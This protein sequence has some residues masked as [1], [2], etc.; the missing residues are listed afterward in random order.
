MSFVKVNVLLSST[1][2]SHRIWHRLTPEQLE[3][4]CPYLGAFAIFTKRCNIM[5]T[6]LNISLS[7][8][9]LNKRRSDQGEFCSLTT[10]S[11]PNNKRKVTYSLILS[12]AFE[13]SENLPSTVPF[14]AFTF[15]KHTP[16]SYRIEKFPSIEPCSVVCLAN[17]QLRRFA[18]ARSMKVVLALRRRV[19]GYSV[20]S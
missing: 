3:L 14:V 6:I 20:H 2:S 12:T 9:S 7:Y 5:F 17:Q 15:L 13:F 18:S 8:S 10:S 16:S 11:Y 19:G 4:A 1:N